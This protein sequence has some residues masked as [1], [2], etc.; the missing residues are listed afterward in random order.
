MVKVN[1]LGP[2]V[3]CRMK[4]RRAYTDLHAER[5][6]CRPLGPE[7]DAVTGLMEQIDATHRT[8]FGE[9]AVEPMPR[10]VANPGSETEK[11][12]PR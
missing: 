11:P 1:Y 3:A 9:P 4:L 8:L 5:L 2:G 7:Y 6:R 12:P 10:H